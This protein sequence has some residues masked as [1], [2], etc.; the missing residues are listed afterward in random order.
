MS[1]FKDRLDEA[2]RTTLDDLKAQLIDADHNGTP[3][4]YKAADDAFWAYVDYLLAKYDAIDAAS[5]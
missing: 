3:G 5:A 1:K 4:A 2:E